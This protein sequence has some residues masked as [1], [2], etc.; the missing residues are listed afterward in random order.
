[1]MDLLKCDCEL[2]NA[3]YL[4]M[5]VRKSAEI[6]FYAYLVCIFMLMIY[7]A[8]I[9]TVKG[10]RIIND[11]DL[12][13]ETGWR[14]SHILFYTVLGLL[15]YNNYVFLLIFFFIGYMFEIIEH[16]AS[17]TVQQ[18]DTLRVKLTGVSSQEISGDDGVYTGAKFLAGN[19]MD[20]LSNATGLVV[21][22]FLGH[23]LFRYGLS[24]FPEINH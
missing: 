7:G 12:L 8:Y 16:V 5:N 18:S 4:K 2:L 21:G 19:P 1:M 20:L 10:D 24:I 11:A 14:W 17:Y 13:K 22:S 23:L 15:F 6:A 9:M 3:T